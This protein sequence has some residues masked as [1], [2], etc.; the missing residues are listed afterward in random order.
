MQ[1]A[2][3]EAAGLPRLRRLQRETVV[4]LLAPPAEKRNASTG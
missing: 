3:D 2:F 4:E 1:Q